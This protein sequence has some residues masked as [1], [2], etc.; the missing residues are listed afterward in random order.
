MK[1]CL[2][3]LCVHMSFVMSPPLLEPFI[4]LPIKTSRITSQDDRLLRANPEHVTQFR[5][6][7]HL[8]E[9][10]LVSMHNQPHKTPLQR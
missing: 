1:S 8:L 9:N 3:S 10:T 6:C 7:W 5:I 4:Q 2:L